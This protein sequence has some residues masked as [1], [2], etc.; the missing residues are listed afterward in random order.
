MA[1][2][3][4]SQQQELSEL[5]SELHSQLGQNEVNLLILQS[6]TKDSLETKQLIVNKIQQVQ[7]QLQE[8]KDK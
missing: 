5:L 8:L 6:Q 7:V 1:K 3:E 2:K 4:K